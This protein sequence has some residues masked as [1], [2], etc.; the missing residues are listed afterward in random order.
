VVNGD[1]CTASS[2]TI[3]IMQS[4]PIANITASAALD[5]CPGQ[6]VTLTAN[7]GSSYL[8]SNG[9]TAS[10]ITVNT[11]G[12]YSVQVTNADNC[13]AVSSAVN[14]SALSANANITYTGSNVLCPGSSLDLIASPGSSW[15][16][17]IKK[18]KEISENHLN[19][20]H[21]WPTN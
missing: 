5:L 14:V 21:Q 10:S 16:A 15:H 11:P 2:N 12:A 1:G 20:C 9:S 18:H 3:S 17:A 13:F 8:W 4:T 7:S 19:Q 6:H